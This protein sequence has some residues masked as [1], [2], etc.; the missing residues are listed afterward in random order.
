V[1]LFFS[2]IGFAAAIALTAIAYAVSISYAIFS[3]V[4]LGR[5]MTRT[6][7]HPK[8][9]TPVLPDKAELNVDHDLEIIHQAQARV[10]YSEKSKLDNYFRMN[11]TQVVSQ[12]SHQDNAEEYLISEITNKID[13]LQHQI[14]NGGLFG[15]V[16]LSKRQAKRDLLLSLRSYLLYLHA[17]PN[18]YDGRDP[19]D[20][21]EAY[22]INPELAQDFSMTPNQFHQK[23]RL[24]RQSFFSKVGDFEDI[25]EACDAYF[26][27]RSD[28]Q[29]ASGPRPQLQ[30]AAQAA[31]AAQQYQPGVFM[32]PQA[33]LAPEFLQP[34]ARPAP[35]APEYQ[36]P[37]AGYQPLGQAQP[38]E[39]PTDPTCYYA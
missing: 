33:Q 4:R 21:F 27:Y 8:A 31:Q 12:I 30:Q 11:R 17:H 7:T 5:E 3:M 13:M 1:A 9:D 37:P 19:I 35:V 22:V 39:Y 28:N 20:A 36:Q 26:R 10:S 25:L 2:P 23:M 24:A 29:F 34:P 38:V 32:R 16:E 14:D 18:E 15:G 6:I